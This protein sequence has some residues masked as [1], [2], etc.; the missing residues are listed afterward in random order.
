MKKTLSK[1]L[2]LIL[3]TAV[4][5]TSMIFS[6]VGAVNS[7]DPMQR[8]L[9]EILEINTEAEKAP[10]I[11]ALSTLF[12]LSQYNTDVELNAAIDAAAAVIEAKVTISHTDAVAAV[13]QFKE[14]TLNQKTTIVNAISTFSLAPVLTA[15]DV[16]SF[17]DIAKKVNYEV[18]GDESDYRGVTLVIK[19]LRK[20]NVLN[21]NGAWATDVPSDTKLIK[22]E[23]NASDSLIIMAVSELSGLIGSMETLNNKIASKSGT[24]A[25]DKLLTYT[26]DVVNSF[27]ADSSKAGQIAALKT[28]LDG[29]DDE[30][31]R[32]YVAPPSGGGGVGGATPPADTNP[33]V[34]QDVTKAIDNLAKAP[35]TISGTDRN[36]LKK[37]L[38]KAIENE[39]AAA[40]SV[41]VIPV[42]TGT[43]ATITADQIKVAD[44]V[45][46]AE[47]V[48][49]KA[50]EIAKSVGDTDIKIEKKVAIDIDSKGAA[51]INV[52]LP[53]ELLTKVRELGIDKVDIKSGDAVLSLAPDF[54]SEVKAAKSVAFTVDKV[55]L[56]DELKAKL[57]K[58]QKQLLAADD[59]VFD[60]SVSIISAEG[61]ETGISAFDKPVTVKIKYALKP[62]E[63]KDKITVLYLADDGTIQNLTGRYDESIGQ[64][65]FE[66][67]HFSAYLVKY[68]EKTFKDVKSGA[69]Y[70]KQVESLAAKGVVGG[71]GDNKF[72]P[73]ANVTRAEF[74]KMLVIAQG[75]Y[76]ENAACSFTDVSK[77]AWYY[78]YIAS[79]VKAGI[80]KG[81]GDGRFSP[82]SLITRQEM[83]VMIA[84]ALGIKTVDNAEK[85]LTASDSSDISAFARNGMALCVM[86]G[87][88][89]GSGNKLDPRG[90]TTRAMAAV[91]IYRYFNFIY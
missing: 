49:A 41:T 22:F 62:G 68:L 85:Y 84:N 35:D 61:N 71:R 50:K 69:W 58:E 57:S 31:Y 59:T 81:T 66:T 86:D 42:I 21:K 74:I 17:A 51:Y 4:L 18:T 2:S 87:F 83:A 23:Y 15:A 39:I 73:D 48:I 77:N 13:T 11:S 8:V 79:A 65:V 1:I 6:S 43:T 67:S 33:T 29:I 56:T 27:A 47:A 10:V 89:Q 40:G 91:V 78:P 38:E 52:A 75:S 80:A 32:P 24:S 12:D 60:F 88:L 55:A 90:N 46:K 54:S 37:K 63:D 3:V 28:Y 25:F 82:D 5:M 45:A 72:E 36:D 70:K 30:F 14:L 9:L 26:A 20:L 76:K 7:V 19:I 64:A 44:F 34:G 53:A 16:S